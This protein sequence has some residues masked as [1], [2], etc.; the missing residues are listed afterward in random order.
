MGWAEPAG[1]GSIVAVRLGV[2]TC[3]TKSTI[4]FQTTLF[5]ATC[6]RTAGELQLKPE[7]SKV[8]EVFV[9]GH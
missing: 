3:A 8:M 4:P 1:Q 9:R 5:I 2:L 7:Q 6:H